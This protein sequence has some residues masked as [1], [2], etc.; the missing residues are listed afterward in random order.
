MVHRP[1]L[2]KSWAHSLLEAVSH[3]KELMVVQDSL[4]HSLGTPLKDPRL[5]GLSAQG[6]DVR[7]RRV[8]GEFFQRLCASVLDGL[9]AVVDCDFR[10]FYIGRIAGVERRIRKVQSHPST[11]DP[12]CRLD[13]QKILGFQLKGRERHYLMIPRRM[14]SSVS[15]NVS[16]RQSVKSWKQGIVLCQW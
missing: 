5:K 1:L 4:G 2:N 16:L 14:N 12:K 11:P 7:A 9:Q 10:L 6:A 13:R 8:V 3:H 15:S